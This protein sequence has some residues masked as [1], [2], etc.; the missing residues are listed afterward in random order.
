MHLNPNP[1]GRLLHLSA[2]IAYA[3][4][5]QESLNATYERVVLAAGGPGPYIT[6]NWL[7]KS[8]ETLHMWWDRR[9]WLT[10]SSI[11]SVQQLA[12]SYGVRGIH[13]YTGSS[14]RRGLWAGRRT[15][16]SKPGARVTL[17]S[18]PSLTKLLQY[19]RSMNE[20]HRCMHLSRL[21]ATSMHV[22]IYTRS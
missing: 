6:M 8:I 21:A 12:S 16:R 4:P 10:V 3:S 9:R 17:F 2:C 19:V 13:H 5:S 11:G 22:T 1:S 20:P 18:K 7:T 15:S 14:P